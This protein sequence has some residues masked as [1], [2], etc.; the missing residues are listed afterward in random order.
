V[1]PVAALAWPQALAWRWEAAG[2]AAR[3]ADPL[4][5]V[6]QSC[7]VQ[8]QVWS[9]AGL[10]LAARAEGVTAALLDELVWERRA[11][12]K[13]WGPR[14]T[15]HL[16]R[17]D[18]LGFWS[19][20]QGLLAPRYE[21]KAWLRHWELQPEQ[22]AAMVVAIGSVLRGKQLTREQLADAVAAEA[23]SPELAERL[24]GGFGDLLKPAA[25]RGELVFGPDAGRNVTFVHPDDWLGSAPAA[26]SGDA[27]TTLTRRYLAA[28]GPATRE[29][30]ARWF[31][32]RS[33]AL[34]GRWIAALGDEVVSVVVDGRPRWAL[35]S[36]L[37]AL[38]AAEPGGLVRLLPGFDQ[39]TITAPRDEDAVVTSATRGAVYRP[40]GWLSPIIARDG[41]A[42]GTWTRAPGGAI[43]LEWFG[44]DRADVADELDR[45]AAYYGA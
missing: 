34:A 31:G 4:A 42:L 30:L 40:Q 25:L 26:F 17:A 14:G 21:D 45:V 44:R 13:T 43:E 6:A 7:G 38:R 35:S 28:Y 1:T 19:A 22:A 5:A 27:T 29:E 24:R 32:M 36:T 37:A 20:A 2:L 16:L 18:E 33:A 3:V 15:L 8:A 23:G 39:W 12:V 41:V 9:S 11:L 10:T